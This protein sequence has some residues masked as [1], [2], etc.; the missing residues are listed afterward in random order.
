MYS[1]SRIAELSGIQSLEERRIMA[2]RKFAKKN[3][4]DGTIL[5]VVP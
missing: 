3:L 2:V 4:C 1:R 5:G